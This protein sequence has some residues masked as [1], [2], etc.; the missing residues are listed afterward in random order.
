MYSKEGSTI[1]MQ[2]I[3]DT[4]TLHG[5]KFKYLRPDDTNRTAP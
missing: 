1:L 4:F 5:T 2:N 3:G